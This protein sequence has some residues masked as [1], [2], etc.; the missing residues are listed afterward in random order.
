M[1]EFPIGGGRP[2][3]L[4]IDGRSGAGKTTMA[5]RI[6]ARHP[7]AEVIHLDDLY[8]GWDGLEAGGRTLVHRVLRPL[9]AGRSARWR[10]WDW[11]TDRPGEW[12]VV[13]PAR[14]IVVEGAGSLSRAASRLADRSLW[15]ELDA[16]A[17]KRR[18]LDRDGEA[19]APYWDRW[20]A[21]EARF[22]ARERPRQW[23]DAVL[24]PR[25]FPPAE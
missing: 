10:A 22:A 3:V 17:R 18:A 9:R 23:A 15:L 16:P 14:L 21:Q 7:G 25:D 5:N 4:L 20:A 24:H 11:E 13:H 6:A 1:I 8:P 19:Y 2:F 12:R